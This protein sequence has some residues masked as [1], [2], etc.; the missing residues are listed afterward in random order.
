MPFEVRQSAWLAWAVCA[1]LSA[2]PVRAER[3]HT[4]LP[5]Q[6]LEVIARRYKIKSSA[7]A[8]A[9]GISKPEGLRNGQVL[10]VPPEGVV[11]VTSG[12]TLSSIAH[13]HKLGALAL[14]KANHLE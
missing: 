9:N 5:G 12:Q 8:A 4:V 1:A 2:S 3:Q 14:A 6:S 10:I 7:L 13:A 11:Y